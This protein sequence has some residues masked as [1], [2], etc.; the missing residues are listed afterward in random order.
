[1]MKWFPSVLRGLNRWWWHCMLFTVT[2]ARPLTFDHSVPISRLVRY[3]LKTWTAKWVETW[4]HSRAVT[5]STKS[6][7]NWLPRASLREQVFINV[8]INDL[9]DR[10]ESTLS[11]FQ[12]FSPA[13]VCQ[14]SKPISG[15]GSWMG[16]GLTMQGTDL[17]DEHLGHMPWPYLQSF[18]WHCFQGWSSWLG[19][20]TGSPPCMSGIVEGPT[21]PAFPFVSGIC[22][23]VPTGEGTACL[24]IT[25]AFGSSSGSSWPS[26][27]PST[28]KG[29]Q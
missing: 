3:G 19:Q 14:V 6:A 24:S 5:S 17:L 11:K 15:L 22:G 4:L 16:L 27:C 20:G 23:I 10:T 12:V 7:D 8:F 9:D 28:E 26:P 2:L 1:M 18:L 29:N 25:P 13:E 21:F